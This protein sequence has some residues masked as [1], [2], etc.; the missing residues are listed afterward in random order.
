MGEAGGAVQYRLIRDVVQER[1]TSR[2]WPVVPY[3]SR[4]GW[5]LLATQEADGTW[6]GGMLAVPRG[7]EVAGVGTIPA[8]RRLLELGW[9]PEAPGLS[10]TKRLLFRLLAEDDDPGYLAELRPAGDDEDLVLRG[11]LLLREAAAAALAQAGHE[12]DPRLRG[13]ARR[14]VA[15]VEAF[16]RSPLA[17]KPWVRLGNQH[18]LAPEVAAPSFH[19]LIML[20]HMPQFRSEHSEFMERLFT[21][22]TQPW[23]RQAAIQQVGAHLV[24]QPHLV[25]GDF[26]ATRSAL[27][28]DMPS[29]LAW[30]EAMARIGFLDRHEGWVK[31]LDRTLDDRDRRKVWTPPR[32]VVMPEQVPVW[33]WPVMPLSD[34]SVG[35]VPSTG[36]SIDVTFRLALIAR[37]AGRAIDLV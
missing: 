3:G 22:L 34:A 21:Y 12:A 10:A 16:F 4:L 11:R 9:D 8:Y 31:L 1:P 37:L 20:G 17:L 36:F 18:V 13:A 28:S 25:L 27:D 5:Y 35:R 15:R 23:P 33:A 2:T 14:L 26:L 29:A 19:L 30:L 24:E 6:P 32:S 7:R